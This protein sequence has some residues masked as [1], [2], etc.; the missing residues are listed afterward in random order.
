VRARTAAVRRLQDSSHGRNGAPGP[1]ERLGRGGWGGDG[2]RG[3]Q[4][5]A[6]ARATARGSE[7]AMGRGR[8]RDEIVV[9][10]RVALSLDLG[11]PLARSG[12]L[13]GQRRAVQQ[14][15]ACASCAA[16][17]SPALDWRP[18]VA[19]PGRAVNGCM[20]WERVA[21]GSG[22]RRIQR[23]SLLR[24]PDAT[25]HACGP[26]LLPS[27]LPKVWHC[28]LESPLSCLL[29]SGPGW[30]A[31]I[32]PGSLSAAKR[33]CA[34]AVAGA[35]LASFA[36]WGLRLAL[37]LA[38]RLTLRRR[39]DCIF[40][41]VQSI[42]AR[43]RR[44]RNAAVAT[45]HRTGCWRRRL[46]FPLRASHISHLQHDPA[47]P[48]DGCRHWARLIHGKPYAAPTFLHFPGEPHA[49]LGSWG[50]GRAARAH[51]QQGVSNWQNNG[52]N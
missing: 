11:E 21:G 28:F 52:L 43:A 37:R 12:R 8:R 5:R 15:A 27:W 1:G 49:D 44:A 6:L 32:D 46:L 29:S 36:H 16:C 42:L 41:C 26:G 10:W 30:V 40:S 48:L 13:C 23:E 24:M 25:V 34:T 20:A 39:P 3:L 35:V 22:R 45:T 18:G 7:L 9:C 14:H 50:A 38:L 33:N 47:P 4:Q 2:V 19:G 31:M 17:A 51:W